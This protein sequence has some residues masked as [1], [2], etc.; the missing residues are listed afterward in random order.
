MRRSNWYDLGPSLVV[1]A[2]I[3]LATLAAVRGPGSGWSAL[4]GPLVLT[5]AVVTADIMNSRLRRGSSWPSGAALI[6]GAGFVLA[7]SIAAPRDP[8]LVATLIPIVGA[9]AWVTL[10]PR[11]SSRRISMRD[12]ELRKE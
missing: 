6:L 11:P 3:I 1:G 7:A 10:L 12:V 9:S 2:G 8:G 4:A 5:L